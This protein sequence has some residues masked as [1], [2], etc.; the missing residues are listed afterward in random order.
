MPRQRNGYL[1]AIAFFRLVKAA[2]LIA[3]GFGALRLL[4]PEVAHRVAAWI[5]S[6]PFAGQ[7]DVVRSALAM[8]T[9][10]SPQQ[11]ELI[12]AG[13]WAYAA[14][15]IVEGAGLLTGRMWAEW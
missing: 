2:I 13:A 3:A 5:V 15:F 1:I 12:A 11:A 6:L 9:R 4:R 8:I 14:I 10:L 7:H